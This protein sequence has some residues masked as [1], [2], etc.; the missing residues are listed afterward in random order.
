MASEIGS[1]FAG[2]GARS[3]ENR[4]YLV[5]R[6]SALAEQELHATGVDTDAELE[7]LTLVEQTYAANARVLSVID[8]LM[9]LL[10]EV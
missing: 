10:L 5:A 7:A 6:Q 2:R 9:K 8:E 4:A 3:D 1:F